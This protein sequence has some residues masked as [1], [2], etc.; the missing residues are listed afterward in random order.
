MKS[1]LE[2]RDRWGHGVALWFLAGAAFLLPFVA[3]SL[4]DVHLEND[5]TKWLPQNDPQSKILNWYQGIFPSEDRILVSWDDCTLTDQRL[6]QFVTELEGVRHNGKL[7]GGS[8]YVDEVGQPS[9]ILKKMVDEGI[10]LETALERT[11]GLL[12]GKGP[13]RIRF[14]DAGR[15]RGD[16]MK[17]EIEKLA[18]EQFRLGARRVDYVMP[19]PGRDGL[20]IE[21][22]PAWKLHDALTDYMNQQPLYD[23]Q[24]AW[25][26]M[27]IDREKTEAFRKALL[28][29]VA[30]DSAAA[31][32]TETCVAETFFTLGNMAA[33]SV[34]LSE[35]G[36]A[37]RRAAIEAIRDAA[38]QAGI[39]PDALH[40]GGRPVATEALHDAIKHAAWNKAHPVWDPVHRSPILLSILISLG[41]TFVM[42]RDLRLTIL[43]QS[44]SIFCALVAVSLVPVTGGSMNMVLVV[45]PTLLMVLTTSAAIH[46]S[47]YWKHSGV[48]HPS[49]SVLK[50]VRIAWLPCAL[51]S[52]TTA[53]GLASLMVS[54]LVPVR[55]FGIYAS[56]GCIISFVSV[57]YL[58]PSMM[59]YW[60]QCPPALG[61]EQQNEFWPTMG[62]V[63][64][65]YRRLVTPL[66]LLSAIAC[67][68]GLN[69]FRT[70]TKVIRYF[71]DDSRLVQDYNFLEENLS[72]I[73]SV[74]TIVKFDEKAQTEINFLDRARLV[75]K[76]QDSLREHPEVSGTLSLA[77]FLDLSEA[78]EPAGRGFLNRRRQR[79]RM[80]DKKIREKLASD[81]DDGRALRGMLA[82]PTEAAD[83][84][85]EGDHVLNAANDEVWRITCQTSI[86][87]D[88][89]YDRLTHELD[90]HTREHL[91]KVPGTNHL[92]TGLVPIFLRTQQALLSSLI[93]SFGLAFVVI[94]LVMA[95]LLRSGLSSLI[96][97]LPNLLPV[98]SVFGLLAWNGIRVDIGTMI[99]ASVALGIAVD[100][101]LHLITW[102]QQLIEQGHSR[103]EAVARALQ[104]CGPALWQTS[105]AIG[106]GMLA[107]LPVELLLIS[108]FG[109]IMAALIG[110]AL[111]GDVVL[112][113]SLLSG[114]LGKLLENS[115]EKRKNAQG[116]PDESSGKETHSTGG[117]RKART[118]RDP[119]KASG[120]SA[121][122]V[123]ETMPHWSR[124]PG[125]S[126]QPALEL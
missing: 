121:A 36:I 80:I 100:G 73:V 79:E 93:E 113:P 28:A 101:T 115:I 60:P 46:L 13:L 87:S 75:M 65:R 88:Y 45:M 20:D 51:A 43:V 47:N 84:L 77:S 62:R 63:I 66:C 117:S 9:D 78:D 17:T 74:D 33:V 91:A 97:M 94:A 92:V 21:D 69:W 102:F 14:D 1:F 119:D 64:Y 41:L 99:T 8:P 71:P 4:S 30:P 111:I 52:G 24:L 57:L 96:A 108:R 15:R 19:M 12:I 86:M 26:R 59:F 31:S 114:I 72:G 61:P 56:V 106:L 112:L 50:A 16:Y 67:G 32:E 53:I 7:E 105:A 124:I 126:R 98:V 85:K 118:R 48:D 81:S 54:S 34:S 2:R 23:M 107:L 55:D 109:W 39:E 49:Q 103:E 5:V 3:W 82:V 76:I 38:V 22:E 11:Q 44:T 29:L 83:W 125:L 35:Q 40:L 123:A 25:P 122:C 110:A 10:P 42:L 18:N 120:T 89:D 95:V 70:E 58:M 104:H 116:P 27:H 90:A 6:R 37:D 68:Y